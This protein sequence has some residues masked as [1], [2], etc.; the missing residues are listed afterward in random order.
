[1]TL[2]IAEPVQRM[3]NHDPPEDEIHEKI[4]TKDFGIIP[5]PK[6]LQHDPKNPHQWTLLLNIVFGLSST[7]SMLPILGVEF[8]ELIVYCTCEQL[9]QTCTTA[10]HF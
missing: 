7:F 2:A 6:R 9:C 3:T 1:M 4:S 10:N 8:V 5:I